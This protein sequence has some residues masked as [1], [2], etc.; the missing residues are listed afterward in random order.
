LGYGGYGGYYR[1][2]VGLAA[3]AVVGG[4]IAASQP[5]YGGYDAGYYG[6]G[7][8]YSTGS[9][10]PAYSTGGYYN[11]GYSTNYTYG[12]YAGNAPVLGPASAQ[13]LPNPAGAPAGGGGSGGGV[14]TGYPNP[15]INYSGQCWINGDAANYRWGDCPHH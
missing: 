8:D 7:P 3:G 12:G 2:G 13:Y 15:L 9:S 5:W 14:G 11:P 6:Y 4:S 1:P 10:S